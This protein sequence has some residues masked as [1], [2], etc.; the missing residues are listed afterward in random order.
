MNLAHLYYFKK[1]VEVKNYSRAAEALFIAQPTLSL[2]VSSLE[3]ELGCVLV[4]KKRNSLELTQDGEDFY[5]AIVVATNAL[6]NA[7]RLIKEHVSAEYGSIRVGTVYSIQDKVWSEAIYSYHHAR[8][9]R[10]QISWKQGTTESLMKDLKNGTLDVIMAGL[11]DHSDSDIESIP[12]TVQSAV[13]LVNAQNPLAARVEVSLD[14]LAGF[15]IVTY[16]NRKG[17]FAKEITSLLAGHQNLSVAYDYNDEI[18]LASLVTADL[19][20]LAIACH[21]WLIDA[22]SDV[23]PVKIVEA[24]EDF[25]QFYISYLKRGRLPFAVEEFVSF[26]KGYDFAKV[27]S[28]P[29]EE[30]PATKGL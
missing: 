8:R 12:A 10:V 7:V 2:A 22:F 15:S 29:E 3:R 25:H 9:S 4:K 28:S 21:S 13:L 26:M 11:L 23:V 30:H 27:T 6:D 19:N 1:L 18:T 24:P 17:P 20:V 16:R 5:D 14:E